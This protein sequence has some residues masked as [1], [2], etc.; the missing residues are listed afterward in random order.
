MA[1]KSVDS[2]SS[3]NATAQMGSGDSGKQSS[4]IFYEVLV[5]EFIP[6]LSSIDPEALGSKLFNAKTITNPKWLSGAPR[7]SI[8]GTVVS[9]GEGKASTGPQVF[10]PFFSH[11]SLPVKSGELV[12]VIFPNGV[13]NPE[14]YWMTRSIG[15]DLAEDVNYTHKPRG[16]FPRCILP[17]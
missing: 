14:G 1:P 8:I 13:Q 12:W 6:S 3:A 9:D 10:Y 5:H 16:T 11:M 17:L 2:M 15:L 7:N 4:R